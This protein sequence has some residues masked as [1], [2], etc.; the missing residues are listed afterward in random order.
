MAVLVLSSMLCV[1]TNNGPVAPSELIQWYS[2]YHFIYFLNKQKFNLS[3]FSPGAIYLI[4]C[5]RISLYRRFLC[6]KIKKIGTFEK[7]QTVENYLVKIIQEFDII[8]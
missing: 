8:V 5:H 4:G 2:V 3:L 7:I 6:Y 1:G